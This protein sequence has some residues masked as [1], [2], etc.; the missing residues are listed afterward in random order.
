M[1]SNLEFIQSV[2]LYSAS[3]DHLY[4]AQLCRKQEFVIKKGNT[5]Y[6]LL[7]RIRY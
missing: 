4:T 2:L 6:I 7:Q 3:V 5:L 1:D